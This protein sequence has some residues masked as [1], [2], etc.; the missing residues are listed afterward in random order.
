ML[1]IRLRSEVRPLRSGLTAP[2]LSRKRPAN[3]ESRPQNGHSVRW[4]PTPSAS[5]LGSSS[6]RYSQRRCRVPAHPYVCR[7]DAFLENSCDGW[8]SIWGKVIW[9]TLSSHRTCCAV[10]DYAMGRSLPAVVGQ[11]GNGGESRPTGRG[12]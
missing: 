10:T 7:A 8:G 4:R 1:R 2:I 5:F 11:V 6:S 12:R 9:E 3:A